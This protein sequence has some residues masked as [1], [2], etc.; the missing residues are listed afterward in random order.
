MKQN[1]GIYVHIPFCEKKCDYCNFISF[2]TD[3]ETK[4]K[5]VNYL[6]KEIQLFADKLK[7]YTIDTIFIGGGTPSTL[8]YNSVKNILNYITNNF[9]MSSTAEITVEAN[10]NSLTREKLVEYKLAGVNR[11]SIGLQTYND[12]LLKLIGR[13]H[14]CKQFDT[15]VKTAKSVG[16][17]NISADVLLGLP[18]QKMRDV[19]KTIKHLVRLK[20]KH[21]SAYGLIVEENTPLAK[22]LESGLY[23]LPDENL[24]VKM[25]EKTVKLLKRRKLYRY[26]VSNFA[27]KGFESK[28][29]LKYWN[30]Q[31][32]V[33]F[34]LSAHS[35]FD[36][37]RCENTSNLA[38]YFEMLE[39]DKFPR[40]EEE[41]ENIESLKE[42]FVMTEIRKTS[43]FS[44]KDYENYFG[45]D[46][47]IEKQQAVAK[48]LKLGLIQVENDRLFATDKGFEVLN[49]VILELS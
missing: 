25:Y 38:E 24:S 22:N 39:Q 11:L 21:I 20:L 9:D 10:P 13:L 12:N 42:E 41:T 35:F 27:K 1:I 32:Y 31:E 14:T 4:E 29:N 2:K 36:G 43:G 33:G 8:R 19:K 44:L 18:T 28:H 47:L 17:E 15:A 7:N 40:L 6:L 26:E 48:L 46:V 37:K 30:M 16:F 23:S 49:Q 45:Q 5:Y 34:G 3:E